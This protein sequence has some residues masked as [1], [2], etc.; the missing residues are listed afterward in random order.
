VPCGA[1]LMSEA[2]YG[3]VYDSIE[4]SIVHTS[5]FSENS[6]A[7]RAGLAALDALEQETLGVRAIA[8]GAELRERLA[9]AL[10]NYEM[11]ASVRGLG[12][13]SGIEFRP[14]R[15]PG[16]KIP[17]EA[18]RVIHPGMFGQVLVMRL[19]RD[20]GILAQ[21]C[22][23]NFMVLKVAPPLVVTEAQ[24]GEFVTAIRETVE[25]VHGS[26]AFW[27]EALGLARRVIGL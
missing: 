10:S 9:D 14:P 27:P 22:G 15:R 17:F 19:F 18:F 24:I 26:G 2:V 5:T 3:A 21:I 1:V 20:H 4:R 8:L 7:M 16:L 25:L 13:L 6:L 23:N 11:V 12:M